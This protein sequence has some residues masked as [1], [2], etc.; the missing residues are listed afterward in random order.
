MKKINQHV[1]EKL[2]PSHIYARGLN[3]YHGGRVHGLSYNRQKE[4][5]FAEVRGT[6]NYYVE[7]DLSEM[8]N[9]RIQTYC[10]CPAFD[11]YES[12]KHLVA[13]MLQFAEETNLPHHT[14]ATTSAFIEGIIS[15][16]Q[17]SPNIMS[18]KIPMQIQYVITFER[19]NK[20]WL[21]LKT[22]IDHC[23][24]VRSIR[25]LLDHVLDD[26]PYF[27][28]Q[29]FTYD[30]D[31]HFY[32]QQDM[33]I[34][35]LLQSF[36]STGDIYTDRSYFSENAYDKRRLLIPPL[37]FSLL[38]SKLIERDV[39]V[40]SSNGVYTEIKMVHD[41]SPFHYTVTHNEEKQLVL[42]MDGIQSAT[43]FEDY[44]MVFMEGVFYFPTR[45][46]QQ[47]LQ[48]VKQIGMGQNHELPITTATADRFFSEALPVLKKQSPVEI[49][50]TVTDEIVEYPLRAKLYLE[51]S[52]DAIV[53]KLRYHYG[54]IEIDPFSNRTEKDIIIIREVEK[55]QEIM[56]LIEQSNFH[57]NGKELYI[58]L[59]EDEEVYD[60]LYTILPMLDEYVELYLTSNIQSLIVENEPIPSTTVNVESA[61]NL[62]EIGFDIS[63]VNEDEV[64]EMIQAVIEKKRFYRLHS[65][66]IVSLEG[67][68]YQSIKRFFEDA[69]VTEDDM[70]DGKVVMPVYRG[71]QI[72]E[73][74]E[75]K[76]SYDPSFHK[77]LRQLQ[78]PEE[79]IYELPSNLEADLRHYQEMGYQWFKSLSEYHLGGIL[80]DDMG[81]GKTVQTIAYLLSEPSDKPHL[82][83]VPSSVIYNWQNECERFAPTLQVE[84]IAGSPE[85]RQQLIEDAK[86]ADIWIT[87]YGTIRQ[88]VEMYQDV[89]FH[90]L[91]LDEA[92]FI[93]NYATKTSKAI[94]QIKATKRYALSGTPIENSID[95]L[96]AIFQVVLPGLMPSLKKF[97]KLEPSKIATLTRPFVLRRLKEDVLKELP[98]KIEAVHVSELTKE[99]KN[100]YIGYMQELQEMTSESIA[101]NNFQQNRM[102]ILAG[103]TRLRQ[104]CCHPSLFIENYEGRSGK[105]DDLMDTI[106][107]MMA[108]GRRMLIFSQFTSMHNL[109]IEALDKLGIDYFYL[110]GQ[111]PAKDR[112]SM[113][114]AFNEGEKSVFLISLRA[115]GT[116]LNLTGADTVI[117]YD[118]WWNPAV[119]DQAA[120]RAHRFGQKNV[121]QVIRFITEG[122]IEE[123]IYEL[124]QKKR[125]LIDQVIQPGETMLSSLTEDDVRQLLSL[126]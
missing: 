65:G 77:L 23:Y 109:F 87:S 92:Q 38:L 35:E 113:S 67:D 44:Q 116:G 82:V 102:K 97:R 16:V 39:T 29:K 79:Q 88:D 37:S 46:Q 10:D 42:K 48:Q 78:S 122:T 94:R 72:D 110:H 99:Q 119:E 61:S 124:Q 103:I 5:W 69:D 74:I 104:L 1:I 15:G 59:I 41:E 100:L 60:F 30:P 17:T 47:T 68:D 115:G 111:T 117:L 93:K 101:A 75:T 36:I 40:E 57:Y 62:L 21:E 126:S 96:W 20:I 73:L 89:H 54:D 18:D 4:I 8:N 71:L 55:E 125:E 123:K 53:G 6:D 84:V 49:S 19:T 28:T 33:D 83:V 2:F 32:L 3:Y 98:D 112:V 50:P 86:D 14:E 22:G 58:N 70:L 26:E 66:A 31:D 91:I 85:E 76:K 63:G 64:T 9:G 24:V 80:A 81:L 120:G 27:F 106:Q 107:K 121:V 56:H 114:Q 105:L 25:D 118:L 12:C 108:N 13:V 52:A 45:S 11:M 34:L 43:Y 90:S 51:K 95:E 7:V